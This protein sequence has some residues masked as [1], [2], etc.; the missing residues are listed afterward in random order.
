M[1]NTPLEDYCSLNFWDWENVIIKTYE[2]VAPALEA[3]EG[4]NIEQ[5]KALDTGVVCV[6]Y[7][8]GVSIYI[9]YTSQDYTLQ[10]IVIPAS[11]YLVER[12]AA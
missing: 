8:N 7:S 1:K 10:N 4:A 5:H 2:T 6:T 9:N 3:V 11:G 12:G